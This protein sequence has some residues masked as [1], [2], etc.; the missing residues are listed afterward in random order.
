MKR[1]VVDTLAGEMFERDHP[2]RPWRYE[3]VERGS[4]PEAQVNPATDDERERYL[5]LAHERILEE[6]LKDDGG[7]A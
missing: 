4:G 1:D 3:F 7:P 2:G 6:E 5:K